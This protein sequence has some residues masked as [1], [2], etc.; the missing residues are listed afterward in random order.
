MHDVTLKKKKKKKHFF[1][2]CKIIGILG[3]DLINVYEL[4]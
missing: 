4:Y 1:I 3:I 2:R